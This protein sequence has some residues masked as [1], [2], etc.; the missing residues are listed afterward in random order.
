MTKKDY[1]LLAQALKDAKKSFEAEAIWPTSAE[2][3]ALDHVIARIGLALK[4]DNPLFN[5]ENWYKA[6]KGN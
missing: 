1:V 4:Q 3:S 2:L 6:I 5:G